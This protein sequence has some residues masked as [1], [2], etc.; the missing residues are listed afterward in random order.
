MD[1]SFKALKTAREPLDGGRLEDVIN[2]VS[3]KQKNELSR[4]E[5]VQNKNAS[6][7]RLSTVIE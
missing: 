5:D 2:E 4:S 3:D 1:E 6:A 7:Q